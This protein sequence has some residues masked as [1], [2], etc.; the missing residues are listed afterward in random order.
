MN[1]FGVRPQSHFDRNSSDGD[2][3]VCMS[4]FHWLHFTLHSVAII[5]SLPYCK[6]HNDNGCH[7]D[8]D[9][10]SKKGN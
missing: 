10:H 1:F 7:S 2:M 3:Y 8:K 6:H 5:V 9:S 4:P